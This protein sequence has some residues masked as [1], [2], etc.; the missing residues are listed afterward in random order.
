[1]LH[2]AFQFQSNAQIIVLIALLTM[3]ARPAMAD[4]IF[5]VILATPLA[6][7]DIGHLELHVYLLFLPK[8]QAI[9]P[10]LL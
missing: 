10:S 8:K 9:F 1:M 6:H 7:Q 4:I 3:Y 5:L 2:I